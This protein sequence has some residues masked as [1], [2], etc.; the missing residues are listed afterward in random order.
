MSDIAGNSFNLRE[1]ISRRVGHNIEMDDGLSRGW[2]TLPATVP[3]VAID[4]DAELAYIFLPNAIK[5][6]GLVRLVPP[7]FLFIALSNSVCWHQDALTDTL[8]TV[9]KFFKLNRGTGAD[10]N[11]RGKPT[12]YIYRNGEY[13]G[14]TIIAHWKPI[15]H[16]VFPQ[17]PHQYYQYIDSQ[18]R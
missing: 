10:Q 15:G 12:S 4:M 7:S 13:T 17:Y 6:A 16:K 2:L 9:P 1:A 18:C 14:T 5:K 3:A 11:G 8:M